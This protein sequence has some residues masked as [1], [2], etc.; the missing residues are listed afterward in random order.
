MEGMRLVRTSSPTSPITGR[1]SRPEAVQRDAEARRGISPART[2]RGRAAGEGAEQT[3]VPPL[4][5]VGRTALADVA[6][7]PSG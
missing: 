5:D 1:P 2:G 4:V 3:S 6:R 7:G